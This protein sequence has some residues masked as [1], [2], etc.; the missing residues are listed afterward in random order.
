MAPAARDSKTRQD[1]KTQ[2]SAKNNSMFD[3]LPSALPVR[4]NDGDETVSPDLA[5][6]ERLS[7]LGLEVAPGKVDGISQRASA[8]RKGSKDHGE[9]NFVFCGI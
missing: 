8:L 6:V 1:S 4:P 9:E 3:A 2:Q 5:A 7:H